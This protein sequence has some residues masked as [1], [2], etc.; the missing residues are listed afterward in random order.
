MS[1]IHEHEPDISLGVL[2]PC[3]KGTKNHLSAKFVENTKRGILFE[4]TFKNLNFSFICW[5]IGID[6]HAQKNE[7]ILKVTNMSFNWF[8]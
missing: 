1:M 5:L 6:S 4:L 3:S 8:F 2:F 7:H